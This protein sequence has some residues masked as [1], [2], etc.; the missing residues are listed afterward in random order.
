MSGQDAGDT[1]RSP[2]AASLIASIVAAFLSV[3]FLASYLPQTPPLTAPLALL[4]VAVLLLAAA[5]LSLTRL[6]A[7][8]WRVFFAVARWVALLTLLFGG[9]AEYL[10]IADGTRGAPLAIMT[11]VLV[12]AAVDVPL[13]LA[14]SVARHQRGPG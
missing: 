12:M 14:F 6:A 1:S 2:I 4:G 5:A 9:M 7:F 8:P 10:F 13:L 3:G 11:A